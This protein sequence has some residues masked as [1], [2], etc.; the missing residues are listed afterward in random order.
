MMY[1]LVEK[2]YCTIGELNTSVSCN[3]VLKYIEFL[4]FAED[5]EREAQERNRGED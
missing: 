5:R 3:D 1:R 4:D 2:G